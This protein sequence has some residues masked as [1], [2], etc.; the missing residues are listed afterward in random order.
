MGLQGSGKSTFY[1]ERFNDLAHVNLDELHTRNKEK[2]MLQE[3]IESHESFI[4]DNT[5][6]QI[7]D[8]E[9]YILLAK[10]NDYRVIGYYF[11]SRISDCIERNSRREGKARVPDKAILATHRKLE[12]PSYKEGFDELYHVEIQNDEFIVEEWKDEI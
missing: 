1:H 4:V 5:N 3:C 12:L 11:A 10:K 2:I 9:L 8:R 7:Q 6:P